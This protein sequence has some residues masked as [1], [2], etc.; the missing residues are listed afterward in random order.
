MPV[1]VLAAVLAIS[2]SSSLKYRYSRENFRIS[3]D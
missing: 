2:N 1:L 3:Y